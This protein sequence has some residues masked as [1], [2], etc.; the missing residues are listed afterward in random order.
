MLIKFN[1]PQSIVHKDR[2]K[3]IK[4]LISCRGFGKSFLALRAA[5]ISCLTYQGS[6]SN[7]SRPIVLVIMDSLKNCKQTH[8]DYLLAFV[9]GELKDVVASV[10]KS[11][12]KI[13]FKGLYPDLQLVGLGDT[14]DGNNLRGMSY[15]DCII[16]EASNIDKLEYV[17][18]SVLIPRLVDGCQIFVIGTSSSGANSPFH[19]LSMRDNISLHTFNVYESPLYSVER[20]E[21][22]K[23]ILSPRAFEAEFMNV[24]QCASN[25]VFDNFTD[26]NIGFYDGPFTKE[27]Y[28]LGTDNGS[29]NAAY[30]VVK[31]LIMED[32]TLHIEMVETWQSDG[33]ITVEEVVDKYLQLNKK[34]N[35]YRV[36][37]WDDRNDIVVSC[38]RK[39]LKQAISIPRNKDGYR[40]LHRAETLNTLFYNNAITIHP[41][42]TQ[43]IDQIKGYRR[44]VD[45]Q[46]NVIFDRFVKENDHIIDAGNSVIAYIIN[47][48]N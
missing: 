17:L 7:H 28:Y 2:T 13:R 48:I 27:V 6:I 21:Y 4:V 14:N 1:K 29:T 12:L 20:I 31:V 22:L 45:S 9:E 15:A 34:Y 16:D 42:L 23:S 24:F 8:W 38:R 40:P 44:A 46:G 33:T 41:E 36:N 26:D 32:N 18:D 35:F 10:N 11:E 25:N 19:K 37:I 39:G 3:A 5:V 47:G 30:V 43:Y